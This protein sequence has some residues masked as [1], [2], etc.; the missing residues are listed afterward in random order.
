WQS[1]VWGLGLPLGLFA[2]AGSALFVWQW[3]RTRGLVVSSSTGLTANS[4]DGWRDG[5]VLS[6][7]LVYFLIVGGQYAKYLRYLLPLL[8][9]LFLMATVT[10]SRITHHALR[11]MSFAFVSLAVL[12]ALVYSVAFTSIY[13]RA[14]PWLQISNWIYQNIPA[15]ASVATE[16]WDDLLPL[17]MRGADAE[18]APTQYRIE[19]LPMYDADDAAKLATLVDALASTDYIIL[20]SPRLYATI[21]RLPARYPISSRYYQ[22]LFNGGLGFDLVAFA[23]NDPAFAGIVVADDPVAAV[24]LSEPQA[25]AD[26][27]RSAATWNWGRADESFAVYDH[28]MPLVFKKTRV[29]SRDELRA[30]LTPR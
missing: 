23:R 22:L 20:A 1:S 6:W 26:Y 25:L 11:V 5:F 24:G 18:R 3:W 8:P 15:N 14:H 13:S 10:V 4:V 21:T 29:L 27:W 12:A 7:A 16:H 17:S 9:F 28:P 30:L 19:T 2:W